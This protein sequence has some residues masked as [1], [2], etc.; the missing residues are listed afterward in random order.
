[1]PFKRGLSFIRVALP[2][3]APGGPGAVLPGGPSTT[4]RGRPRLFLSF[5]RPLVPWFPF[6]ADAFFFTTAVWGLFVLAVFVMRTWVPEYLAGPLPMPFVMSAITLGPLALLLGFVILPVVYAK[7]RPPLGITRITYSFIARLPLLLLG[8]SVLS[9]PFCWALLGK[10]FADQAF[11][12]RM[13]LAGA[14]ATGA[15]LVSH[16]TCR[17]IEFR[18]LFDDSDYIG[19]CHDCGCAVIGPKATKDRCPECLHRLAR[20]D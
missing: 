6:A 18:L 13:L 17:K 8:L 15:W 14:L 16:W 2:G 4:G 1:M 10:S 11:L 9:G 12:V 7:H 5:A 3:R 19:L 20:L